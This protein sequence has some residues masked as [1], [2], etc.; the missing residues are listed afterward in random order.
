MGKLKRRIGREW[1]STGRVVALLGACLLSVAGFAAESISIIATPRYPWN[2]KVD[3]KFTIDGTSGTKYDT[4]FTAKDVAGG[5]NLTMKTLYKSDGTAANVAKEQLLPGTYNWVW[6]AT[7]DLTSRWPSYASCVPA[8]STVLF[9]NTQLAAVAE[10]Y[11]VPCGTAISDKSNRV[12]GRWVKADGAGKSVQFAFSDDV[13]TKCVCVHFKQSGADVVGYA[14]WARY[15]SGSE[16]EG[17]DF[18]ANTATT[19]T[20][21]TSETGSG[22]GLCKMEARIPQSDTAV[23]LDRVMVEGTVELNDP[24]A[25]R[26][27]IVDLKSGVVSYMA[28]EP[29]EGWTSTYK[30]EKMVLRRVP[31]QTFY[32]GSNASELGRESDEYRHQVVLSQTYYIGMFEVTQ[33]QYQNIM[34]VNPSGNKGDERPV[35]NVSYNM[36]RG[37]ELG[38][39]W[40]VSKDVDEDCFM[41]KIRAKTGIKF[42]L[43]SE[44]QWECACRAG[45]T[46]ALYDG[47]NLTDKTKCA[48]VAALARYKFNHNGDPCDGVPDGKGGYSTYHTK[49]GCYV[50]NNWQLYDTYGNVYEWCTDWYKDNLGAVAVTD[51][52]GPTT[53]STRVMRGGGWFSPAWKCRSA[54]RNQTLPPDYVGADVGFRVC[55]TIGE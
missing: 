44:A 8:S 1:T 47:K 53:G 12:K 51:P 50:P 46:A 6:D 22:Y 39:K 42:D 34:G 4:S 29:N 30:T 36:I 7:A 33:R 16:R 28:E 37:S 14:K 26:Y 41:G 9:K 18:D 23:V 21:A 55:V 49:V 10:F 40:P 48:N 15:V 2:G 11:A 27:M 35:E 17:E 54:W 20:V 25:K 13:Y 24:E 31:P 45:T 52:S 32:M 19:M 43:P 38:A 5:T 3:L